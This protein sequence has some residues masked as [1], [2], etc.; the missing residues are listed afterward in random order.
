MEKL[1]RKPRR[2][3]TNAIAAL[4]TR[5]WAMHQ[6]DASLLI[7]AKRDVELQ[8]P[9]V[10]QVQQALMGNTEGK[11]IANVTPTWVNQRLKVLGT[12]V[13]VAEQSTVSVLNNS[14]PSINI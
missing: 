1:S 13:S 12:V 14:C 7:Q 9:Y 3:L 5:A 10:A 8:Q 11:T 6:K 2:S 4:R